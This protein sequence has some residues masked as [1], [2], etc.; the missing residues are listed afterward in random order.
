MICH[1]SK[2]IKTRCRVV[3]LS[4]VPEE[5]PTLTP[6]ISVAST[7]PA[8]S[9][10][11]KVPEAYAPWISLDASMHSGCGEWGYIWGYMG[12]VALRNCSVSWRAKAASWGF[13]LPDH[14]KAAWHGL[15]V[16]HFSIEMENLL[17]DL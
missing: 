7:S 10:L 8:A 1:N 15:D 11:A 13:F 2:T 9:P 5:V 12:I 17:D 14:P 3:L 4:Q 6:E 16:D